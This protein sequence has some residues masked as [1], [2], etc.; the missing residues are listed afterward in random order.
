M[1]QK[2]IGGQNSLILKFGG[3]AGVGR[4]VGGGTSS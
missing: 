4:W 3:G 1:V 2:L